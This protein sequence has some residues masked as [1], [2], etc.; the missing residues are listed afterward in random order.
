MAR[1]RISGTN[2]DPELQR[3]GRLG[4]LKR[5]ELAKEKE[6]ITSADSMESTD[7]NANLGSDSPQPSDAEERRLSPIT[8]S[9]KNKDPQSQYSHLRNGSL[10][11]TPQFPTPIRR[12]FGDYSFTSGS[13]RETDRS[14]SAS[15]HTPRL[16][17]FKQS[18]PMDFLQDAMLQSNRLNP[19]LLSEAMSTSEN[20][21]EITLPM[22]ASSFV[23]QATPADT[24]ARHEFVPSDLDPETVPVQGPAPVED[25]AMKDALA[26]T[27]EASDTAGASISTIP[28]PVFA[29]PAQAHATTGTSDAAGTSAHTISGQTPS[30]ASGIPSFK[31]AEQGTVVSPRAAQQASLASSVSHEPMTSAKAPSKRTL[32][33]ADTS[34]KDDGNPQKT[35]KRRKSGDDSPFEFAIGDGEVPK[36]DI[37]IE[38]TVYHTKYGSFEVSPVEMD[39]SQP[40]ANL[41]ASRAN[42]FRETMSSD[43]FHSPF[44]DE[45]LRSLDL[46]ANGVLFPTLVNKEGDLR[47]RAIKGSNVGTR[48][49]SEHNRLVKKLEIKAN[50]FKEMS[51]AAT[52]Q[53]KAIR[54]E[55]K[56]L[57]ATKT[58]TALAK[59]MERLE[60]GIEALIKT[61]MPTIPAA[62]YNQLVQ[63]LGDHVTAL[64]ERFRR[65]LSPLV[66]FLRRASTEM[67]DQ[68][69]DLY[70][71]ICF[72]AAAMR[73]DIPISAFFP[74]FITYLAP[75]AHQCECTECLSKRPTQPP[76]E[77]GNSTLAVPTFYRHPDFEFTPSEIQR[78]Q[79]PIP[80]GDI[81]TT[82]QF[83]DLSAFYKGPTGTMQSTLTKL[84]QYASSVRTDVSAIH[85]RA[86]MAELK[87]E[88]E[89]ASLS[90]GACPSPTITPYIWTSEDIRGVA[91]AQAEI[92][93]HTMEVDNAWQGEPDVMAERNRETEE[94]KVWRMEQ[95]AKRKEE[96]FL[97]EAIRRGLLPSGGG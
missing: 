92:A 8:F 5:Q 38:T 23:A 22:P 97:A 69:R 32:S 94:D 60:P 80:A 77:E 59:E 18:D 16:S 91:E 89:R 24:L 95:E 36:S 49:K 83:G 20:K 4:Q 28:P 46:R 75:D 21:P 6:S 52:R 13:R 48:S 53:E 41:L 45:E 30:T 50:L 31:P 29:A 17:L 64:A 1:N 51:E 42:E 2:P 56:T 88:T 76:S 15:S 87:F 25:T 44:T 33:V 57:H 37:P 84:D 73:E 43:V 81:I 19:A 27:A 10:L 63:H 68:E 54:S 9:L 66:I 74:K 82:A 70:S 47:E 34:V 39:K 11:Q 7:P 58:A 72:A 71:L 35:K 55:I 90:I 96:D 86:R 62:E 93:K 3:R 12:A 78:L 61:S 14:E 85:E 26:S 65:E 40:L 79:E 67:A